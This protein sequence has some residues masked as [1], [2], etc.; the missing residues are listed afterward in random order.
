MGPAE[1]VAMPSSWPVEAHGAEV[2][3]LGA[4]SCSRSSRRRSSQRIKKRVG[5]ASSSDMASQDAILRR[6][7]GIDQALER[8]LSALIPPSMP[9]INSP[10]VLMWCMWVPVA[11]APSTSTAP[12]ATTH[13]SEA[14]SGTPDGANYTLAADGSP[15]GHV[16]DETGNGK[17]AFPEGLDLRVTSSVGEARSVTP[18]APAMFP[19]SFFI[20]DKP[21]RKLAPHASDTSTIAPYENEGALETCEL[22]D[23]IVSVAASEQFTFDEHDQDIDVE[24]A[25][26][27]PVEQPHKS[28]FHIGTRITRIIG[29]DTFEGT[30]VTIWRD[31][32]EDTYRI[33]YDD[34][35]AEDLNAVEF[36]CAAAGNTADHDLNEFETVE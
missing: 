23:G 34:G 33:S 15:L 8:I 36:A 12:V 35:D 11:A 22:D 27:P 29:D 25:A 5:S 30:L 9:G 24:N 16:G 26:A 32:F 14:A 4:G 6:L 21:R 7:D 3:R 20:G 10:P 31:G 1:M 18:N 19:E 13:E 2:G 28:E 17:S